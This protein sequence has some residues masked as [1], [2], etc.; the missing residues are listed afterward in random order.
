MIIFSHSG[1]VFLPVGHVVPIAGH[2]V[3]HGSLWKG[4]QWWR[5]WE[6]QEKKV[7]VLHR[8]TNLALGCVCTNLWW[9][10]Q[11][12]PESPSPVEIR[13]EDEGC[14]VPNSHLDVGWDG[15]W[16]QGLGTFPGPCGC[17]CPKQWDLWDR[18]Q[19]EMNEKNGENGCG[20][21]WMK[22]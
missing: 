6:K 17:P 9:V 1:A 15:T 8:N 12:I 10:S 11:F 7:N 16:M 14:R 2:R 3:G 13:R 21:D 18:E 20:G 22:S 5:N 4:P 19:E